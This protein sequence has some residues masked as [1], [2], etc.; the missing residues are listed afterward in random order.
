MVALFVIAA[1]AD[2]AAT[3]RGL[4]PEKRSSTVSRLASETAIIARRPVTLRCDEGYAFTGAGSDTLGIAFPRAG[5]AYLDPGVCRA[6]YDLISDGRAGERQAEA[7]VVLAHEAIHLGGERREGVTECL[8]L[9]AAIPLGERLGL[10][11]PHV[12]DL[13]RGQYESRLA[14]R[15]AIRAAYAL[16]TT[17]RDGEALDRRPDDPRFP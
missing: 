17:C 6:L 10:D 8:A 4:S 5:I 2:R 7:L 9:Q 1:R 11:E 14:E 16:P 12:R 15:S 13:M 3:W